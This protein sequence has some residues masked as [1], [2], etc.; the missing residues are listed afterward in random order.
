MFVNGGAVINTIARIQAK[1]LEYLPP[2]I[3]IVDSLTGKV[4]DLYDP[5]PLK[6]NV[7]FREAVY[8]DAAVW[9]NALWF[10]AQMGNQHSAARCAAEVLKSDRSLMAD[11]LIKAAQTGNMAMINAYISAGADVNTRVWID[12]DGN[13]C[14][15]TT[16]LYESIWRGNI[17]MVKTLLRVKADVNNGGHGIPLCA[18]AYEGLLDVTQALLQAGAKVDSK[19]LEDR[20]PL[21]I[22]AENGHLDVVNALLNAGASVNIPDRDG[23]TAVSISRDGGHAE[24]ANI[25]QQEIDSPR[26]I[27]PRKIRYH[28]N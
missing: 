2:E 11:D 23:K 12:M 14:Y 18:A 8:R 25:I 20:T 10:F 17:N 1:H 13:D 26:V 21:Y 7:R 28:Y 6:T 5:M 24:I 19:D 22:S 16:P 9:Q 27:E 3:E 15:P 4:L